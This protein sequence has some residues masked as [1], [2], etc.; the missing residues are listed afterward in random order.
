MVTL[1]FKK[2]IMELLNLYKELWK[3]TKELE[4]SEDDIDFKER[5]K[6]I[7]KQIWEKINEIMDLKIWN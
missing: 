4:V 7:E 1:L 3:L 6:Y 2:I 5:F